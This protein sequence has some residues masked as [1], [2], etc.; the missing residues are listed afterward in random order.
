MIIN[1]NQQKRTACIS[2]GVDWPEWADMLIGTDK[3]YVVFEDREQ[4]EAWL[5]KYREND[6]QTLPP[7]N[8]IECVFETIKSD[9][10]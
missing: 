2:Y 1:K 6:Y 8:D 10:A 3:G 9:A 4:G 7:I 5:Q